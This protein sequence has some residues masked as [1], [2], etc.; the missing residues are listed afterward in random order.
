MPYASKQM[1]IGWNGLSMTTK[2]CSVHMPIVIINFKVRCVG[3]DSVQYM[4]G[5]ILTHI[6]D[7]CG[8]GEPEEFIRVNNLTII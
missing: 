3:Q 2:G 5:I 1:P 6:S 8:I 4:M 7:K